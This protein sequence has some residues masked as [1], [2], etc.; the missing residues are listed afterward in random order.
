[1]FIPFKELKYK[2]GIMK[3]DN[4]SIGLGLSCSYDLARKIGGDIT[5]LE[6]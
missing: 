4:D 5:L 3:P 2:L 1:L 6:S